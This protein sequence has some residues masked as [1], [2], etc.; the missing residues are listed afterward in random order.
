M[1]NFPLFSS[2][3]FGIALGLVERAHDGAQL[4]PRGDALAEH[5]VE[6]LLGP[7][8][9]CGARALAEREL[10]FRLL[11]AFLRLLLHGL[12]LRLDAGQ[13]G[14]HRE[15]APVGFGDGVVGGDLARSQELDDLENVREVDEARVGARTSPSTTTSPASRESQRSRMST[16][17]LLSAAFSVTVP[18]SLRNEARVY[19]ASV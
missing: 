4:L 19:S 3:H 5:I 12:D 13:R 18:N 2:S 1:I 6:L 11:L 15:R 7:E 10:A 16:S 9:R 17:R 8:V 14:Q